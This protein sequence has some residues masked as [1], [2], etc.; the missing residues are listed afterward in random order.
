MV[1]SSKVLFLTMRERAFVVLRTA[2]GD[3]SVARADRPGGIRIRRAPS[4]QSK[5]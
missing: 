2:E 5:T 1:R 4:S 3:I